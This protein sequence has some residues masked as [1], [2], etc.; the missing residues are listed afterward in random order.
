MKERYISSKNSNNRGY[1]IESQEI[2]FIITW[3]YHF[4]RDNLG[5]EYSKV[6][7]LES[8]SEIDD[9]KYILIVIWGLWK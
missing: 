3:D 5:F 8:R 1:W 6:R 4:S 9:L 7:L 2:S